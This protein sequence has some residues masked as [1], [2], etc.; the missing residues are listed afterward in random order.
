MG[1]KASFVNPSKTKPRSLEE[2]WRS[3]GLEWPIYLRARF[4]M[5]MQKERPCGQEG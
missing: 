1:E 4:K 5:F 2:A 3:W